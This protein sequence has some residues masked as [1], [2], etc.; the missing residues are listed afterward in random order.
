MFILDR[1]ALRLFVKVLVVSFASLTG[2]YVM[3]VSIENLD[4]F[5]TLAQREGGFLKVFAEYYGPRV[6]TFFDRM[7]PFLSLLSAMF[8]IAWMQRTNELIA[9]QAGGISKGRVVRPLILACGLVSL[10]GVVNRE[11]VI[12]RMRPQLV[13]D[14]HDS[15]GTSTRTVTPRYDHDTDIFISGG[16]IISAE[17]AMLRPVFRLPRPL[18]GFSRQIEAEKAT[19][20]EAD[21]THP[22]GY[23]METVVRPA[24]V[25]SLASVV[26][27][28]RVL[29]DTPRDAAWLK[30]GQ[31]FVA[32]QVSFNQLLAGSMWQR[33]A[34]SGELVAGLRSAGLNY[35]AEARVTVHARFLQPLLDLTLVFLGLPLVVSRHQRG[36]FVAVGHTTLVV[37]VFVTVV[38]ASRALG[39][40][41]LLSPSL[42]AWLP[43]VV[44]IPLAAALAP[45]FW[46]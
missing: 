28:D 23:L 19:Y 8:V 10:F 17:S 3:V 44:F 30:P 22:A 32:S 15:L 2:L 29:I 35:G 21:E 13:R 4:E 45:R 11:L 36:L 42:A 20:L 46:D 25:N 26:V 9:I 38:M 33:F 34:S 6:L 7:Y 37:S 18:H 24:G 39:S 40:N 43:L 27:D 12:P 31:C 16:R 5:I 14:I 1:Y 41:Y